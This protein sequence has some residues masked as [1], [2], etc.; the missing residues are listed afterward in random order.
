MFLIEASI[1]RIVIVSQTRVNDRRN[2]VFA[3]VQSHVIMVFCDRLNHLSGLSDNATVDQKR[4]ENSI[5]D[6]P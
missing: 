6:N 2:F 1:C 4:S 5:K 3:L